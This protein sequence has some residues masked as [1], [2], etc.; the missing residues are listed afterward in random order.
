DLYALLR[1]RMA[2]LRAAMAPLRDRLPHPRSP[3][4]TAGAIGSFDRLDGFRG[5]RAPGMAYDDLPALLRRGRDLLRV[6]HGADAHG[7]LPEGV[8]PRTH[9]HPP[10]LR[11]HGEDHAGDRDDGRL[12]L[13]QRVLY[14]LV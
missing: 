7:D 12:R 5:F 14:L 6:R 4:D 2:G 8:P 1:A 10:A 13:C 11:L 9:H 3:R